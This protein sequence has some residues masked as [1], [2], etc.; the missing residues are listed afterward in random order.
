MEIIKKESV[1]R[2][3]GAKQSTISKGGVF[4]DDRPVDKR[5]N[6]LPLVVA[7]VAKCVNHYR[8]WRRPLKT[9][10][11]CPAYYV[12][13]TDWVRQ[14]A[15]EEEADYKVN[16][17]TFDGVEIDMT[18]ENHLILNGDDNMSWDFYPT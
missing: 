15:T 2:E 5:G 14:R 17:F 1:V 4:S 7:M 13:F 10:Y 12:R 11:L 3:S 16:L 6:P 18:G 8:K 9:I